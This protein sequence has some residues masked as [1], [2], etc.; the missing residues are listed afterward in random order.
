MKSFVF[1]ILLFLIIITVYENQN[2]F[3]HHVLEEISVVGDPMGLSLTDEFLYVSSF[4]YPH[5]D[6]IDVEKSENVG[7]ITT[8]SSGIM[9]VVA[10]P[11]KD[12]IYAAP[13]ESGGIDVYS[14]S[15]KLHITTIP[16]PES[17]IEFPTT[18]NQPYGFRSDVHFVTGGWSL[19]YN[20][21][22][23]LVYVSD[24]NAH[25]VHVIDVNTD[26][27]IQS[28]SVPRH[29]FS[30]IVDP[31]SEIVLVA[32]LA[33]NEITFL[34]DATDEYSV[35]PIH[36]IVKTIELSGDLGELILILCTIWHMSLI[37]D[38]NVLL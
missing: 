14:L 19:D 25:S 6:I 23:E 18:S 9:D 2:A 24:Y 3:A 4:Q 30:V 16:L 27:V 38:V 17:V 11:D 36:E 28:I 7:F 10:V 26:E 5:I 35:F 1:G 20:P 34:E 15:S 32:S 13:F 22:K 37:E 12:K 29:P 33:R 31:I 8:S 21:T